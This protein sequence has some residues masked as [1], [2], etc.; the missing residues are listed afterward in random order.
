MELMTAEEAMDKA[1]LL[2]MY[3]NG[4]DS[5]TGLAEFVS[6]RASRLVSLGLARHPEVEWNN[7]E[8]TGVALTARGKEVANALS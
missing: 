1:I 6:E 3:Q 5:E 2:A 8:Q 7:P 4:C